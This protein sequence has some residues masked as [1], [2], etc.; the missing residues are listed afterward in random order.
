MGL[1]GWTSTR[2]APEA[3]STPGLLATNS[4]VGI[5]ITSPQ[6]GQLISVPAPVLSTANSCSHFG[7]LKMTSI[8]PAF[9]L[10]FPLAAYAAGRK[11]Q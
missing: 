1:T 10:L 2:G 4:G 11:S 3:L 8:M 9:R 5:T 7:Q 6:D